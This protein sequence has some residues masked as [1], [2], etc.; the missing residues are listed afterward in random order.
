MSTLSTANIES[1]AANTP[2]VIKDL[3]GTECGQFC[4]AWINFNGTG[5]VEIRDNFN[6]SSL[7]DDGTG[8]YTLNFTNGMPNANYCFAGTTGRP[9][10]TTS[11]VH[12]IEIPDGGVLSSIMTTTAL[13]INVVYVTSSA[14]RTN[15]D[16]QFV[17]VAVFGG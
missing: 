9:E 10:A 6:I 15:I 5:T 1:K 7:T 2:P 3:N 13:K 11:A 8:Q 12:S 14:N 4:R 16:R 17:S